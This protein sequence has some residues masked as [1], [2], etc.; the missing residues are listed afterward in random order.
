MNIFGLEIR[1]A[2]KEEE[3]RSIFPGDTYSLGLP[4]YPTPP[5]SQIAQNISSYFRGVDMISDSLATMP[6]K[7]EFHDGQENTAHPLKSILR[8]RYTLVKMLVESVFNRGN[9]YCYIQRD[10]SGNVTGLRFLSPED[11]SI[12][13]DKKRN[14]VFYR[15]SLITN[16]RIEPINMIHL[17]K[18]TRDGVVGQSLINYASRTLSI[19]SSTENAA[20][21]FFSNGCQLS[22]ILTVQGQLSDQQREQI[23]SS[24]NQT[25]TAGGKGV[26][27]LPGNMEYKPIS[28]SSEDSQLLQ[29]RAFNVSEIARFFGLMPELLGETSSSSYNSL[30][31][32]QT[33]YLLHTLLPWIILL[34]SEFTEKLLKPSEKETMVINLDE[35]I[36]LRTDKNS[37]AN[38]YSKLLQSG[39]LSPNECRV[40]LGYP[41]KEGLDDNIIA[42]TDV[43]QNKVNSKG[44]E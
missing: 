3:K 28:L 10:N 23:R 36:L 39:I 34:E 17:K 25:Y 21:E 43:N 18:W 32:T 11:V 37:Q 38:Y 24:W 9:G 40:E 8:N 14:E 22:G 44:E 12:E 19:A 27:I 33:H 15:C 5:G 7:L 16:A 13:Y 30:E 20:R 26:C 35:S 4:F 6:L 29:S 2:T 42:F 31:A 1:R 41:E